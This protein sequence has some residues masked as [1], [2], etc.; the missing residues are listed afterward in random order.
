[1]K[2]RVWRNVDLASTWLEAEELDELVERIAAR[3][4]VAPA[5]VPDLV[6]E[7]RIALWELGPEVQVSSAWVIRTAANKTIDHV[8]SKTRARAREQAFAYLEQGASCD[9]EMHNLLRAQVAALPSSL[10]VLYELRYVLGLSEREVAR[11]LGMC[12]ASVRWLDRCCRR[13]IAGRATANT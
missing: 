12:R 3:Y 8:R 5:D 7:T 9:P 11:E 6:Q 13:A 2:A 10:K 1:M 4:H